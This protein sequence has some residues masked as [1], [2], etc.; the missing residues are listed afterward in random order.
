VTG[1]TNSKS[2]P[3]SQGPSFFFGSKLDANIIVRPQ[4]IMEAQVNNR[5]RVFGVTCFNTNYS[6]LDSVCPRSTGEVLQ[7]LMIHG[8]HN[9]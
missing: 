9:N 5:Q 1:G 2:A 6:Q 7:A 8:M 4:D 3:I